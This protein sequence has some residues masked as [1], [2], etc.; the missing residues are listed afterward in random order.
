MFFLRNFGIFLDSKNAA[1]RFR[2]PPRAL[3]ERLDERVVIETIERNRASIL[4]V[5]LLY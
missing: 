4:L 2:P 1:I 5:F 3:A